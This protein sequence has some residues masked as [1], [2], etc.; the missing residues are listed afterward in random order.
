MAT[1]FLLLGLQAFVVSAGFQ[2]HIARRAVPNACSFVTGG[3]LYCNSVS[4]GF[5]DLPPQSQAPCLCYSST[6]WEPD[7][8]DKAVET[9]ADYAITA[10]PQDY[11]VLLGL[12]GFCSSIGDVLG[13]AASVSVPEACSYVY[14]GYS[15]CN[16]VSPGFSTMAGTDQAPCLCYSSTNWVPDVF[17]NAVETCA[18]FARTASPSDYSALLENE[19]FCTRVGNVLAPASTTARTTPVVPATTAPVTPNPAPRTTT[20]VPTPV[21][22]PKPTQTT[23][24]DLAIE[25]NPGCSLVSYGLNYCESVSPGF[26][27]MDPTL[28]APCLCY[29]STDWSPQTF[30]NAVLT[31]AEFVKTASP[32]DYSVFSAL[33]GFCTSIGDVFSGTVIGPSSGLGG[34]GKPL[35]TTTST[36]RTISGGGVF[37][38]TASSSRTS[39]TATAAAAG[40]GSSGMAGMMSHWVLKLASVA[41]CSFFLL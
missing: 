16:S 8:F 29:S 12:E 17:D 4:P 37:T 33:E 31:C 38:V 21:P 1:Q 3:V 25:T 2:D 10:L 19:G 27:T 28:Q 6:V 11:T 13:G 15:Y 20:P 5:T 40:S 22:T 30:D 32:S 23:G 36:P 7:V 24:G 39:T 26:T 34:I 9:C 14:G 18:N 41:V 35:G